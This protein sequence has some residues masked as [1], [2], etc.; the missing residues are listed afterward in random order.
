MQAS[1]RQD[2]LEVESRGLQLG[3]VERLLGGALSQF[4]G[5][6]P[7]HVSPEIGETGVAGIHAVVDR[8]RTDHFTI[9]HGRHADLHGQPAP[10]LR[11]EERTV[12][13]ECVST[14]RYRLA[15]YN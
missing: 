7:S 2:A 1:T 13:K 3:L 12:G 15:P 4:L 11:S 8:R 5:S 14:C 6:N 9:L 10:L